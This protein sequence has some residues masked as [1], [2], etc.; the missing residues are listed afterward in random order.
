[1][2]KQSSQFQSISDW[3]NLTSNLSMSEWFD[4]SVPRPYDEVPDPSASAPGLD[5]PSAEDYRGHASPEPKPLPLAAT[6]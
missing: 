2:N 3:W 4:G 1:M 5:R 6:G